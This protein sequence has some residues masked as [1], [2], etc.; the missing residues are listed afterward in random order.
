MPAGKLYQVLRLRKEKGWWAIL[1]ARALRVDLVLLDHYNWLRRIAYP[2][3]DTLER[4]TGLSRTSVR[5]ALRELAFYGLWE[6]SRVTVTEGGKVRRINVYQLPPMLV[7]D[8]PPARYVPSP[9]FTRK[10]RLPVLRGE[11][12]DSST[13]Y[14]TETAE[15]GDRQSRAP[16]R[17]SS[18]A[19]HNQQFSALDGNNVVNNGGEQRSTRQSF[20]HSPNGASPDGEERRAADSPAAA[21]RKWLFR[22]LKDLSPAE[23]RLFTQVALNEPMAQRC[24]WRQAVLMNR[25]EQYLQARERASVAGE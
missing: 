19:S 13:P 22:T 18:R 25:L 16:H 17:R 23:S 9:R 12:V 3:Y 14:T 15:E 8:P 4:E 21:Y 2:N 11:R 20:F 1:S 24:G 10:E 6:I 7:P 5:E